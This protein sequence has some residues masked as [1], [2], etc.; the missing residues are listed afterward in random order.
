MQD[1]LFPASPTYR[2]LTLNESTAC[3]GTTYPVWQGDGI[4]TEIACTPKPDPGELFTDMDQQLFGPPP[5][6]TTAD[7]SSFA[8]SYATQ[9][10]SP[11]GPVLPGHA[12]PYFPDKQVPVIST[13]S[14]AFGVCDEWH[15]P[16]P[17]QTWPNRFFAHTGTSLGYVDTPP[18][19]I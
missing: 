12:M 4:G 19:R 13:L 15:A 8:A 3:A 10:A 16:A 6:S 5:R 2:G 7:M 18:F 9:K 11:D 14:R 17:C 1:R